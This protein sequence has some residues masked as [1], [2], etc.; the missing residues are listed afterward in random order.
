MKNLTKSKKFALASTISLIIAVLLLCA[1]IPGIIPLTSGAA[2]L[3]A[4]GDASDGDTVGLSGV[5]E[6]KY[7]TLD[8]DNIQAIY[9]ERYNPR[10]PDKVTRLYALTKIGDKLITIAFPKRYFDSVK[11]MLVATE[12]ALYYGTT[13][14]KRL[15]ITGTAAELDS[16]ARPVLE[17]W[18]ENNAAWLA[19]Y[20]VISSGAAVDD[21][22]SPLMLKADFVGGYP[23]LPTLITVIVLTIIFA[24]LTFVFNALAARTSRDAET[25]TE[26]TAGEAD[27]EKPEADGGNKAPDT[28][29]A[30]GDN[31]DT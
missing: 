11:E 3:S 14:T 8:I 22:V 20:G 7:Y 15:T 4:D 1:C 9:A 25:E 2:T 31:N 24:V 13:V 21:D 5:A 23:N 30:A 28:D 6:R 16:E 29:K 19:Y 12:E 27:S 10:N 26:E 18:Y 17:S